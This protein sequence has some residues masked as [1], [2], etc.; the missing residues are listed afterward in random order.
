[1]K[2]IHMVF[3]QIAPCSDDNPNG[4]A[5][6]IFHIVE[7]GSV[8]VTNEDGKPLRDAWGKPVSKKLAADEDPR[9][10]AANLGLRNWR[11]ASDPMDD[12]NRPLNYQPFG[13][14]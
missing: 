12:F 14:A 4:R 3:A 13:I 6:E 9:K 8:I 11:S 10:V 7:D 2:T 1:M 5:L